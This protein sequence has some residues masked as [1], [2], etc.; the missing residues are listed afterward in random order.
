MES[1]AK[2]ILDA[3]GLPVKW[4]RGQRYVGGFIGSTRM[5][6]RWLQP[7]VQKWVNGVE[8]L[9]KVTQ[10]Y[11]QDAYVGLANCLQAEWQYL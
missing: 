5:Q 4:S 11:P 2:A 9:A 3:A 6:E 1:N 7:M 10:R 8:K